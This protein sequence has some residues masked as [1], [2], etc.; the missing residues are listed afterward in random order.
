MGCS[1]TGEM[2]K[3]DGVGG[4]KISWEVE[5][6][7]RLEERG[8]DEDRDRRGGEG[9][10]VCSREEKEEDDDDGMIINHG[11][12][13]VQ[14]DLRDIDLDEAAKV[15]QFCQNGCGCQAKCY[16]QFSRVHI[17]KMRA[18]MAELERSMVDM[19]IMG[20]VMAFTKCCQVN[21]EH[22][23]RKRNPMVL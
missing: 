19:I 14:L 21:Q 13:Y 8:G 12:V 4:K 15:A 7:R 18:D 16:K 1:G 20:Q 22:R 2:R 6:V 10:R 23:E 9:E 3:R 5:V 17:T 11:E